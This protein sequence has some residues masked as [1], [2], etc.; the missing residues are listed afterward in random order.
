MSFDIHLNNTYHGV[1]VGGYSYLLDNHRD[2]RWASIN[3]VPQTANG[4]GNYDGQVSLY[5]DEATI[6]AIAE[7][8]ANYVVEFDA[9]IDEL[10]ETQTDL[11][12]L[13]T[14]TDNR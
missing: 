8:T 14:L 3:I 1:T 13:A 10:A 2:S 9:E 7:L 4:V 11:A 12:E 5:L 6:R